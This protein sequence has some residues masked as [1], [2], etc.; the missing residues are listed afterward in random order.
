MRV[1]FLFTAWVLEFPASRPGF[2][3]REPAA[4][5]SVAHRFVFAQ[6][7]GDSGGFYIQLFGRKPLPVWLP[8]EV[9]VARA[10]NPVPALFGDE[11]EPGGAKACIGDDDGL[12]GRRTS[13]WQVA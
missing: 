2:D 13:A 1:T 12:L 7:R 11:P 9:A 8:D 4:Q 6:V 10:A 5:W 3:E